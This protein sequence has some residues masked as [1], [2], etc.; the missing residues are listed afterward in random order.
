MQEKRNGKLF[1]VNVLGSLGYLSLLIEWA[2][3]ALVFVYPL[4]EKGKLSWFMPST[5]V[6]PAPPV[7]PIP[8]T[9][10]TIA[11]MGVIVMLCLVAT[12][13][14]LIKLPGSIGR[15][16]A[17]VTHKSAEIVIPELTSHKKLTGSRLRRLSFRLIVAIKAILIILPLALTLFLPSLSAL[18]QNVI[19]I[20]LAFLAFWP[21]LYFGL[22]TLFTSL[23]KLD[24]MLVW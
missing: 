3:V 5:P 18:P 12:I 6:T 13:Y 17:R 22:Q 21:V 2:W 7:T 24:P 19:W 9:P 20:I 10:F 4:A 23:L 8:I 16:G 15:T 14:A 11:I 1:A